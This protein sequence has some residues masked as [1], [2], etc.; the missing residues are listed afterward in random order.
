MKTKPDLNDLRERVVA[1]EMFADY[2]HIFDLAT[3]IIQTLKQQH[4]HPRAVGTTWNRLHR[5]R[6]TFKNAEFTANASLVTQ[7]SR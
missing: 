2:A 4:I 5:L 6:R 7:E 3:P 1:C